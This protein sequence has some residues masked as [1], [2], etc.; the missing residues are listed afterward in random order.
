M[1]TFSSTRLMVAGILIAVY[2]VFLRKRRQA[3]DGG[4]RQSVDQITLPNFN[5]MLSPM[6][7]DGKEQADTQGIQLSM[8]PRR[9]CLLFSPNDMT[10]YVRQIKRAGDMPRDMVSHSSNIIV[11]R[12]CTIPQARWSARTGL[13]TIDKSRAYILEVSHSTGSPVSVVLYPSMV[14]YPLEVYST[15]RYTL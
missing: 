6:F 3:D 15:L 5:S 4:V 7:I 8:L 11:G 9:P 14:Y 13:Y 1:D 12:S 10:V 2:Q